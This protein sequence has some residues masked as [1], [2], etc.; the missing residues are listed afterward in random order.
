MS[1]TKLKRYLKILQKDLNI[2]RER[3]AKYGGNAP[4]ELLNQIEDHQTAIELVQARLAG[5]ISDEQLNEQLAPL[6]ISHDYSRANVIPVPTLPLIFVAVSVLGLLSFIS[7]RLVAPTLPPTATPTPIPTPSQMSG[8]FN[9]AVAEIGQLDPDGQLISSPD[10]QQL[11]QWIFSE[12]EN[13]YKNLPQEFN[14]QVWHD[15]PELAAKNVK[16]GLVADDEAAAN[17][18]RTIKANLVIYGNLDGSQNPASFVPKFYVKPLQGETGELDELKGPF[19]LGAPISIPIPLDPTDPVLIASLKPEVSLRARALRWFTIGLIWDLAGQTVR[20]LETF[21]QAE[22]ELQDWGEKNQGK[23]ILYY[24]IGREA[25]FLSRDEQ[26]AKKVFESA[27]AAR[28][29]AE[30]YFTKALNS[31][32]DY[33]RAYMGLGGV[34]FQRA[35]RQSPEERLAGSELEQAIKNYEHALA[36]APKLPGDQLQLEARF[37]V[38]GAYQLKGDAYFQ[39]GFYDEANPYFDSTIQE[40]Q[41]IIPPLTA[42]KQ[43]RSLGHVFLALGVA[44]NQQAII[45]QKQGDKQGS[46]NLYQKAQEAYANCMAQGDSQ[47]G[48]NPADK[49]LKNIIDRYCQP[50]HDRVEQARRALEG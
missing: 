14:V 25:L 40:M 12:L 1:E 41:A 6:N 18:A 46:L 5:S 34:Y 22:Q 13:E 29:D 26:E 48:G 36:N 24:F 2:L 28:A 20:A 21:Q 35:Q 42:A 45:R 15:G 49:L 39:L 31:N 9:I 23:E 38:A 37:G 32:P 3:E 11:G 43:Q 33:A 4:V 17:L 47:K 19:Q 27:E 30:A 7:Y 44:Y 8:D 16:I 10:G 50:Y